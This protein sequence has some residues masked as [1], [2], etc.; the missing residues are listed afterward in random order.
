MIKVAAETDLADSSSRVVSLD[1]T[2]IEYETVG[3]GPSVI[4]VPG[5]LFTAADYRVFALAL[6]TR[7]TVHTINRRGRGLSGP[8]GD[9]YSISKE[10]EDLLAVRVRTG[11]GFVVG[12][13]YGGLVALEA[14]RNNRSIRRIAVY[15]PGVSIA[16]SIPMDWMQQ[17]EKYLSRKQYLDA[18]V[19][20]SSALGPEQGRRAPHWM[21]KLLIPLFIKSR[22]RQSMFRLLNENLREHREVARLDGTYQNYREISAAVLLMYGGKS[23][24]RWVR[25]SMERLA[26]VLHESATNEFASLDHFGIDKGAPPEVARIIGNYFAA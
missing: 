1:G 23:D 19:T 15:E 2:T 11:A 26:E 9:D 7:F 3:A 14:A 24:G 20:F 5:A 16:G 6:G 10:C 13:S 8:Q 21:M 25:L 12:H 17:Y 4:V 22:Q 18:F